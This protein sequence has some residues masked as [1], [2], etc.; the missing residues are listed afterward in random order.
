[1]RARSWLRPRDVRRRAPDALVGRHLHRRVKLFDET[2]WCSSARRP[3]RTT[4]TTARARTATPTQPRRRLR[5]QGLI[6]DV[7]LSVCTL[8]PPVNLGAPDGRVAR[9]VML[10][11]VPEDDVDAPW[12]ESLEL[13]ASACA[14]GKR[15][16]SPASS[17]TARSSRPS[18]APNTISRRTK[19]DARSKSSSARTP[20]RTRPRMVARGGDSIFRRTP[21]EPASSPR[22]LDENAWAQ[23]ERGASASIGGCARG[24][25]GAATRGGGRARSNSR[26]RRRIGT[27]SFR[28]GLREDFAQSSRASFRERLDGRGAP[29]DGVR[30]SSDV[31]WLSGA[32][33]RVRRVDAH[34][35]GREDGNDGVSRR[36]GCLRG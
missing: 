34:R 6:T 4:R 7:H 5:R 22:P 13:L 36:A 29:Q 8:D 11:M 20:T 21:R 17:R 23:E 14:S 28:R 35:D 24:R 32:V 2:S 10:V 18:T 15:A 33:H 25:R 3:S 16:F 19:P 26:R 27:R 9:C 30:V 12:C 31:L 1:M